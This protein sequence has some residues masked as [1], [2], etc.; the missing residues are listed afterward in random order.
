M[1]EIRVGRPVFLK[2]RPHG[3]NQ[4]QLGIECCFALG[5]PEELERR[6]TPYEAGMCLD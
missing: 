6:R 4:E 3:A 5:P 1:T 2:P